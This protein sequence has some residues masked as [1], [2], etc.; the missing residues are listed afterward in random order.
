MHNLFLIDITLDNGLV[1]LF[2]K[3]SSRIMNLIRH[4][5]WKQDVKKVLHF[6]LIFFEVPLRM[7][8]YTNIPQWNLLVLTQHVATIWR[9]QSDSLASKVISCNLSIWLT[10]HPISN[11]QVMKE[12]KLIVSG[13]VTFFANN[14][15]DSYLVLTIAGSKAIGSRTGDTEFLS[16]A[17]RRH[18]HTCG[19]SKG[20]V[21]EFPGLCNGPNVL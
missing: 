19:C 9:F 1:P 6:H 3:P 2:E 11:L 17:R 13:G 16:E 15:K 7:L 12:R 20:R 21:Q 14:H 18:W 8:I 10:N 4:E 5:N